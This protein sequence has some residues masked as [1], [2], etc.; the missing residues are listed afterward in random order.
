MPPAAGA[1]TGLKVVA[2]NA[3]LTLS[4]RAPGSGTVGGYD[5]HYTSSSTV[6]AGAAA[7]TGQSPSPASGWVDAGHTG[8][9]ASHGITGLTNDT[10]YRVR[11]RTTN[12]G[13]ESAWL[14]GA[15]TPRLAPSSDATLSGL[16][17]LSN[18]RI[19]IAF[20]PGFDSAVTVYT[21]RT[22]STSQ[23]VRITPTASHTDATI[24]VGKDGGTLARVASGAASE[25]ITLDSG[26]N[27]LVIRV[28]AADGTQKTYTV[29]VTRE[30]AQAED[31]ATGVVN[32]GLTPGDGTL[33]ATWQSE[34]RGRYQN[35]RV[36]WKVAGGDT[37]LNTN[38]ADGVIVEPR[39]VYV[40]GQPQS[41]G[42]RKHE[43]TGLTN[44][45]AYQV[46]VRYTG[47]NLNIPWVTAQG[48]PKNRDPSDDATLGGLA[49][50]DT[51]ANAV[52]LSPAFAAA[53]TSYTATVL[54]DVTGVKVTP[55]VGQE[56]ATV[57][58]DGSAVQSGAA[59]STVSLSAGANTIDVVVT[60][61]DGE[62][63][64]TYRVVVTR[65][66]APTEL[67]LSTDAASD[68][69]AEDAG[70]VTV[71]ATLNRPAGTNGVE[72]TLAAGTASTATASDDYTL[73]AAYTIAAGATS[74]TADVT[75]A[76]DDLVEDD[77]K[78]V[79]TTEVSGLTVTGVTLTITD[80]DDDDAKI[81]F[82][83]NA[84][85]TAKHAVSVDENVSGGSLNVPVDGE[86]PAGL[87]DHV[88]HR[89]AQH[90]HG[91][92]VRQRAEPGRLPHRD[93]V[94]DVR[95]HGHGQHPERGGD[96]HQRLGAGARR[97]HR[98]ED[99]RRGRSRQRPGR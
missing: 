90:R 77:E 13:G 63:T 43:I 69:A 98:T 64:R 65:N 51:D 36:R 9:A 37:W 57:T 15:G 92:G 55:R 11:V 99:R 75:I 53:I 66:A 94:G 16:S 86:P 4:W 81:A 45:Q 52:T 83:T 6:A 42:G 96:D 49:L 34:G 32:L 54:H 22:R 28:T 21:G 87:L 8:T 31:D 62:S 25:L 38:G 26:A 80:D 60:A 58:V 95:P 47:R 10:R 70:S 35:H 84:S 24:Q 46:E 72:V 19:G 79:L 76:D 41:R 17:L 88:R 59:S 73:P 67:T 68:T 89:G 50:A 91:D 12:T 97:D 1:P 5:V 3:R 48:T 14:A 85:G 40:N 23:A 44:G 29:T 56:D 78:L 71:T 30:T 39:P 61:E 2:G 82:G 18:Q 33:L 74:A 27:I 20:Q 93:Q 7:Q